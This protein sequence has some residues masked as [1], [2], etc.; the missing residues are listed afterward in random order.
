MIRLGLI[1]I[2]LWTITSC[3]SESEKKPTGP[4][5]QNSSISWTGQVTNPVQGQLGM[6]E[7]N[8]QRR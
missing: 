2:A 5:S 3:A 6:I 4:T 7:R 1:S 8:Q